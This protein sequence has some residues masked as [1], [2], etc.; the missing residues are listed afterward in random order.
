MKVQRT[1]A[2]TAAPIS[3]GTLLRA[4]GGLWS[5]TRLRE[6]VGKELLMEFSAQGVFLVS[7]GKAALTVVLK[8]L[9][10]GSNRRRV[11]IPAYTCFSVPSAVV[12]AGLDVVL[13]DIDPATLDFDYQELECRLDDEVLCVVP[14]HLFG[15]PADVDR[16]RNLCSGKGIAV[17]EDAAQAMGGSSK[18]RQVGTLGDISIF[19]LGRGKNLTCGTGGI[20]LVN[21]PRY[22]EAVRSE[23]GALEEAPIL[24]VLK[25][26]VEMVVMKVFIHPWLY[27]FPVGLP[28][29]GLGETRF[30]TDFQMRR[31]DEV[32]AGLLHGWKELVAGS[33][34]ERVAQAGRILER[35][36]RQ[37]IDMIPITSAESVNLRLPLLVRNREEKDTV[38]RRS[39]ES[40]AGVSPSYPSTIQAV[41][42]LQG[43]ITPRTCPGAQ[44]VV[45]RLVTLPT[46][47]YV[48]ERDR[49]RIE[50][51]L[52][53][54]K[55][56]G[57]FSESHRRTLP[58][59][60][61][62]H[63]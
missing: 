55:Q 13:C 15:R 19:S 23:Y 35:I 4:L 17:V 9:A 21:T 30:C 50:C 32:R 26:W 41:P 20:I 49:R 31:M 44:D 11:V 54:A 29:L 25:N 52:R 46:H 40:G 34:R 33:N 56:D 37:G 36:C 57:R 28:F 2:P 39:R 10:A 42:E 18:G 8:A 48:M 63:R 53:G 51:I 6:L 38:C 58:A 3:L 62:G 47:R 27:W 60:E 61:C 1:V 24:E 7:S 5:G 45:D 14:T 16:V 22:L 59:G 12:R 43:R